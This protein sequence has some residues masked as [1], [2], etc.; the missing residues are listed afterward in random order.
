MLSPREH[1]RR[2]HG[3]AESE[4][5]ARRERCGPN[6]LPSSGRRG[7]AVLL[8]EVL[9]EPMLALLLACGGVYLALGDLTEAVVLLVFVFVVLGI[10]LYQGF[11]TEKALHALRDL[12]SPRALV[13]REEGQ[14]RVAG[15]EVVPGDLVVLAE[16]DRVPADG[17]LLWAASLRTDE[18]LL[19]GEAEPVGK[20][21][22]AEDPPMARPGGAAP[23]PFVFS[24]TL[25][26]GGQG[27]ARV[28]ATAAATELGRIG[29]SLA[30]A[31]SETTALEAQTGRLVRVLAAG[32]VAVSAGVAVLVGTDTG[33]WLEGLLAGLAVGMSMIPEEFPLILTIFLAL[34][35]RRISQRRVLTRR[36][37]AIE[38]LGAATVLCVDKTGTL[39]ENRM[40]AALLSV[41]EQWFD[42]RR[43]G[44]ALPER[45]HE[46]LE[47]AVLAS[48]QNP[49][50]AMEKAI[51]DAGVELLRGTEHLH[52][53]W[54]LVREYPLSGALLAVS[55]V[56]AGRER[57]EFVIGAK[58]APE[59]IADLCHLPA[60]GRAAIEREVARMAEHGLRV[61]GVARARFASPDLPREQHD[62]DFDF[63]GL[64]GLSDPV[65]AG[66]AESLEECARAGIRTVMITGDAPSTAAAVARTIGLPGDGSLLGGAELDRIDDAELEVRCRTTAVFARVIPE[67]KL[68]LVRAL[69]SRGEVVAM[70]GDGVN[71]AP[72][73][74]AAHIGVAMGGRGTDVAREAADLVLLDDDFA[75]IVAAIRLGRRIFDNIRKAMAYVVAVH[76]PIAGLALLPVLFGLPLMLLP[77]HV[78]F[79]QLII[80]P[81]CSIAFEAEP[82]EGDI[83]RR[84][85]RDAREPL[86]PRPTI[87]LSLLQ[88]AVALT[89]VLGVLGVALW[90]GDG[91]EQART[92][93]FSTLVL[94]NLGLILAERS[95]KRTA[96]ASLAVSNP[97]LT[98]VV[99]G[100][101]LVLVVSVTWP[102][103]R[104]LLGFAVPSPGDVALVTAAGLVA[105]GFFDLLKRVVAARPERAHVG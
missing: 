70:T 60:E 80:D 77:L 68:R 57:E 16:G 75:S 102:P 14:R 63:L 23:S 87:A 64:V 61:L 6:E 19:T 94:A 99:A 88:G 81:A 32:G 26:A 25:V 53:R 10:S 73:L 48:Q 22:T 12:S 95:S 51:N 17:V 98:W 82:E 39:T 13:L 72:A 7:L 31:H 103:A 34:G 89:L 50:D 90:R 21:A 91:V 86:L 24:G 69:Q 59:A 47:Y 79:L 100:S 42:L 101:L 105:T 35:A 2:L 97:A 66:V 78:A 18:S 38:A 67:Q 5:R 58:G 1:L 46:L 28:L 85:P 20:V 40:R 49:F 93:S 9:R 36:L 65:R 76:V 3:L 37:A 56:W 62:F 71:D 83:M 74:K 33:R 15:R 44:A 55:H 52:P 11:R 92:L 43:D 41:D 29:I 104:E 8:V 27:I 84:P 54:T 30:A 45:F 96:L 4:V